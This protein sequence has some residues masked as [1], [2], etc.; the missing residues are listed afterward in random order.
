MDMISRIITLVGG[1]IGISSA[2]SLLF[3]IA[4]IRSGMA[5]E[6]SRTL[7]KGITKVVVGGAMMVAVVG[8]V[9][10]ILRQVSAITF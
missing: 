3:G 1:I 7:D 5:N 2:V 8:I 4:D 9:A 10:Y 6:D